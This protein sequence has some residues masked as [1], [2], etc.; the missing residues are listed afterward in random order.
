MKRAVALKLSLSLLACCVL[1]APLSSG[2]TV[3]NKHALLIL[4]QHASYNLGGEG[5]TA[6][7]CTVT[8]N[9]ESLLAKERASNPEGVDTAIKTLSQLQFIARLGADGKVKLT[10]NELT[11]QSEEMK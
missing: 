8:P 10:H 7:E 2:Q 3:A 1:C 4:A 6:F 11:G 9:W 5:L